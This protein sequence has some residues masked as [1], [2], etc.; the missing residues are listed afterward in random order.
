MCI[1]SKLIITR[2][3]YQ[4]RLEVTGVRRPHHGPPQLSLAVG[5]TVARVVPVPLV[6]GGYNLYRAG[7]LQADG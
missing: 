4:Q 3:V 2:V 7:R 1:N 5:R 6:L